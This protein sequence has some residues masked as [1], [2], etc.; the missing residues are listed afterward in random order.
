M[1]VALNTQGIHV[2]LSERLPSEKINALRREMFFCPGCKEKVIL[3]S[4][5]IKIPH[6]AHRSKSK[7]DVDSEN[8]SKEHLV[9]KLQLYSWLQDQ[10]LHP[11]IEKYIPAISQRADIYL[12]DKMGRK[13]AIEF[14]CSSLAFDSLEKRT[15]A[16]KKAGIT[17]V[18]ILSST[19]L[20]QKGPH[21]FR[22]S[23][24]IWSFLQTSF[25]LFYSTIEQTFFILHELY[26]FSSQTV[27]A[28]LTKKS[29]QIFSFTQLFDLSFPSSSL[30]ILNCWKTK[31]SGW[32]E[33]AYRYLNPTSTFWQAIYRSRLSIGSLP[34]EIGLPVKGMQ[35]LQTSAVEWQFWIWYDCFRLR[36]PGNRFSMKFIQ[37][38]FLNRIRKGNIVVRKFALC[39]QNPYIAPS[40]YIDFLVAI[41][42]MKNSDESYEWLGFD[43]SIDIEDRI[44]RAWQLLNKIN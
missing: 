5:A 11:T 16:Y 28:N 24:M 41:G 4:G 39:E 3:R 29:S 13:F 35:N 32:K 10:Y 2:L 17:P 26:P 40:N 21:E 6:F 14:Q 36:K 43:Q 31:R 9:G 19:W 42:V 15:I 1:L 33:N 27:F 12:E 37:G 38:H 34:N 7:C 18:W 44:K 23:P 30:H 20:H 25:V 22:I 8:E